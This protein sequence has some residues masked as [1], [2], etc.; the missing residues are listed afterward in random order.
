MRISNK[1]QRIRVMME[2]RYIREEWVLKNLSEIE[3]YYSKLSVLSLPSIRIRDYILD[4]YRRYPEI[5]KKIS[6]EGTVLKD[7][8][9]VTIL[10]NLCLIEAREY[11]NK[12]LY[13]F[14]AYKYLQMG[15]YYSWA[16][17]TFYYAR[18]YL[19]N[20]Y[21]RVQGQA[22]L[23]RP[24]F[25]VEEIPR[26]SKPIHVARDSRHR[27]FVIRRCPGKGSMHQRIWDLTL[28]IYRNF[29]PRLFIENIIEEIEKRREGER[30]REDIV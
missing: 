1:Q 2:Y 9:V 14:L 22:I 11:L 24:Q 28:E 6:R 5:R 13:S 18:F 17:H 25:L 8:Q 4:F 16:I 10:D 12:S 27:E 29:K 20:Y 30:K 7:S 26:W 3:E 19:N 15:G 23:Y 21:C